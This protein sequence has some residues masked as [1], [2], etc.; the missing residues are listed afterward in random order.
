MTRRPGVICF[1]AQDWWYH[2]RAHSEVQLMLR[3]ARTQPVLLVNSIG[4]RTPRP[5]RTSQAGRRIVRK[6]GSIARGLRRPVDGLPNFHVLSPVTVPMLGND[7]VRAANTASVRTQVE[8]A[9]RSIGIEDPAIFVTIPTAWDVIQGMHRRTL[10]YNRADKHSAFGDIDRPAIEALER[11]LL[12]TSDHVLYV[13]HALLD[14]ER[15]LTGDR[16]VFLDH[17]VDLEH[18]RPRPPTEEPDDLAPIPHPRIGFFGGI[19]DYTVDV[20]LLERTAREIPDAQL[21]LIGDSTVPMN[22]LESLPN[23]HWLGFR[24]YERIP[25]YAS[26]FDVALMPWCDS[27]WIA[28]CNPVKMKEYLALG[29]PVVSTEFPEVHRYDKVLTVARDADDFVSAVRGRLADRGPGTPADRRAAVAGDAWDRR[30]DEV[31]SLMRLR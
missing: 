11:D 14:A 17:G 1:A 30:A 7:L 22:G 29:L 3:I 23:V 16:A 13:S 31:L 27:E 25:A 19:N 28:A 26:G 21:V 2:N 18:F 9:A 6:V 4:M 10:L 15:A 12:R 24:P 8:L 20:P 5:G